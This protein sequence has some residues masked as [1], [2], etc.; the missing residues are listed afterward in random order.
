MAVK[1]LLI[2]PKIHGKPSVPPLGLGYLAATLR[3]HPGFEVSIIDNEVYSYDDDQLAEVIKQKNPDILGLTSLVLSRH[4]SMYVAAKVEA[5]YIVFGGPQPTLEERFYLKKSNYFVVRGE[6]ENVFVNFCLAIRDGKPIEE[7]RKIRGLAYLDDNSQ[8]VK[9]PPEPYIPNIDSVPFP[10]YDL[11][12]MDY[13]THRLEGGRCTTMMT[14]RGC[15][16]TCVYCYHV[17]NTKFRFRTPANVIAEIRFLEKQYG[18]TRYKFFDDVFTLNRKHT[19][20]LMNAFIEEKLDIRW[21]ILTRVNLVDEE[22]LKL[23]YKAGLRHISFGIESG[24]PNTLKRI[25]KRVSLEQNIKAIQF[26]R[27]VGIKTKA[28]IILGFP[29]ET[30]QDIE[31]TTQ[32]LEN[33]MPDSAQFLFATPYQNTDMEKMVLQEGYHIQEIE[34]LENEPDLTV[35]TF[36]SRHWTR[37]ELMEMYI[38]AHYRYFAAGGFGK[39]KVKDT[40]NVY[41][42]LKPLLIRNRVKFAFLRYSRPITY[43]NKYRALLDRV[44]Q[45][46][47]LGVQSLWKKY[48][49]EKK[50]FMHERHFAVPTKTTLYSDI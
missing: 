39:L 8:V 29:W 9:N 34:R 2:Q 22:L 15:P 45:V 33:V 12:E 11:F 23:M 3:Q 32:F 16:Y 44:N 19:V 21:Q 7:I 40:N 46:K 14:S 10:A 47:R 27:K 13:Y 1:V 4:R 37:E 5:P 49:A 41:K 17:L 38:E 28:Y 6:G 36:D 43:I 35:S 25:D 48:I 50:N 18:I 30:Q 42:R 26:C 24:S 31:L 20:D